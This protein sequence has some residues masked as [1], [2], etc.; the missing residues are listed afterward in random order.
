MARAINLVFEAA[1]RT[2]F[3]DSFLGGVIKIGADGADLQWNWNHVQILNIILFLLYTFVVPVCTYNIFRACL[4][5]LLLRV[6]L[7]VCCV[8]IFFCLRNELQKRFLFLFF[9]VC[10]CVPKTIVCTR[11]HKVVSG[12]LMNRVCAVALFFFHVSVLCFTFVGV[13]CLPYT[14]ALFL[15]G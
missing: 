11:L 3:E 6:A 1:K 15:C 9:F 5:L 13:Y 2:A 14:K 10:R 7:V 8:F 12:F 4:M